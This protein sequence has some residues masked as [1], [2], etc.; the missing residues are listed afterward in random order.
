[1]ATVVLEVPDE[2]GEVAAAR[3]ETLENMIQQAAAELLREARH[4]ASPG[5]DAPAGEIPEG[6]SPA[7]VRF[8]ERRGILKWLL[9][10]WRLAEE[11]FPYA[12]SI[13]ADLSVDPE[14]GERWISI[15]VIA[16]AS[17]RNFGKDCS[18][19]DDDLLRD[20][21]PSAEEKL[22]ISPGRS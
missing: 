3:G 4:P 19:L 16:P 13:A 8:A 22:V 11:R 15:R 1:M 9:H 6:I 18:R 2:L 21:P 14:D 17:V 7:A 10:T 5:E 12:T 20:L